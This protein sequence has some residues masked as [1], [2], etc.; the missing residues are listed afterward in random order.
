MNIKDSIKK[1]D[2]VFEGE[3]WFGIS[4]LKS[5]EHIPILFWDKKPNK[6]S[7]SISELVYHLID[8]RG[9]VIEKLKGNKAFDIE[10][11][12]EK[13]WRKDVSIQNEK[14]KKKIL[15]E[16]IETQNIICE[17]LLAKPNSWLN[18]QVAGRQYRNEYM[19]SGVIQHDIYHLGQINMVY[20]QL[21]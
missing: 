18:E 5:L 3:P 20:S 7:H 9:F 14:E 15:E 11:N 19:I 16:L 2:E 13:D 21:K 6:V 8:W 4:M 1:Y 12:S 17:L 10:L